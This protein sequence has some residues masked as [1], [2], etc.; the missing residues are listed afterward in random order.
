MLWWRC[1]IMMKVLFGHELDYTVWSVDSYFN[2]VYEPEWVTGSIVKE[3]IKDIDK[4]D[5]VDQ[6]VY[7]PV[8]GQISPE[9]LSGGIKAMLLMTQNTEPEMYMNLTACGQNCAK[10]IARLSLEYNFTVVQTGVHLDFEDYPFDILCLNNM[11]RTSD[12]ERF[13]RLECDFAESFYDENKEKVWLECFM[14]EKGQY[15]DRLPSRVRGLSV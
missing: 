4:S 15:L 3:M 2:A 7:S 9:K 12:P 10:W 6:C 14:K 13:I 5:I 11:E 8:L 1:F